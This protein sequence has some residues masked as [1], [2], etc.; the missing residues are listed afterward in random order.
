MKTW[1][2]F[3]PAIVIA[4]FAPLVVLALPTIFVSIPYF[5]G[6]HHL[7]GGPIR[8]WLV[9]Y[10]AALMPSATATRYV[11]AFNQA[12]YMGECLLVLPVALNVSAAL[13]VVVYATSSAQIYIGNKAKNRIYQSKR[14]ASKGA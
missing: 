2:D 13:L 4:L 8:Q 11:D 12:N 6:D 1:W 10:L 9:N 14:K 7:G 3:A 5:G